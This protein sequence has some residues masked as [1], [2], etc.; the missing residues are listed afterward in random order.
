MIGWD[1]GPCPL[2]PG[3]PG[4]SPSP[5]PISP[6]HWSPRHPVPQ[7]DLLKILAEHGA[8]WHQENTYHASKPDE[9]HSAL[10]GARLYYPKLYKF[11][12][13]DELAGPP[14]SA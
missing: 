10:E 7:V 9:R 12:K 1:P 13:L 14:P 2:F 3:R 8:S 11:L 6:R 5:R 4:P